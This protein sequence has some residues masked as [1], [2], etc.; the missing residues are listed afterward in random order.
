MGFIQ[1]KSKCCSVVSLTLI[2][3]ISSGAAWYAAQENSDVGAGGHG[4]SEVLIISG[5]VVQYPHR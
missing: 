3:I 2:I 5:I 1:T 4:I